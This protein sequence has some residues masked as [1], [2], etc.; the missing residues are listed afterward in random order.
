MSYNGTD[1]AEIVLKVSPQLAAKISDVAYS[2]GVVEQLMQRILEQHKNLCSFQQN[3]MD[4]MLMHLCDESGHK[5]P[6]RYEY[7]LDM[8]NLA[9]YIREAEAVA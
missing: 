8:E 4:S 3:Q 1:N 6:H 2:L 5:L 9:L 7:K